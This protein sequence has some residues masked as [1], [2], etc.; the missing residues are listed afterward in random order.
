MAHVR[1]HDIF[2]HELFLTLSAQQGYVHRDESQILVWLAG[3][4]GLGLLNFAFVKPI[5]SQT[6]VH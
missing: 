5:L 6:P 3:F 2:F 1:V 4:P